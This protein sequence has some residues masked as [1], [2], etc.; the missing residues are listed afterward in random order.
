M[1]VVWLRSGCAVVTVCSPGVL[2]GVV[3]E[4][5]VSGGCGCVLRVDV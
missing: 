5:S 2:C 3:F 1:T 4:G